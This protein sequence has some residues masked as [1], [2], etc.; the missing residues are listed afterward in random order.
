MKQDQIVMIENFSEEKDYSSF[1]YFICDE[2]DGIIDAIQLKVSLDKIDKKPTNTKIHL[3]GLLSLR[4]KPFIW[5]S[6]TFTEFHRRF[7]KEIFNT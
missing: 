3:R 2:G 7:L 1:D 4:T 5:F 6:A